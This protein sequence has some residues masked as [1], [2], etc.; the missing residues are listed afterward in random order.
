MERASSQSS[1]D[2]DAQ[3]V[4]RAPEVVVNG[5]SQDGDSC[6]TAVDDAS[7]ELLSNLANTVQSVYDTLQAGTLTEGY[8]SDTVSRLRGDLAQAKG[9]LLRCGRHLM[10]VA[11]KVNFLSDKLGVTSRLIKTKLQDEHVPFSDNDAE[12]GDIWVLE[13]AATAHSA[14]AQAAVDLSEMQKLASEIAES[15]YKATAAAE[16]CKARAEV[17]DGH[18]NTALDPEQSETKGADEQSET[19]TKR[20]ETGD[21]DTVECSDDTTDQQKGS[22]HVDDCKS[23]KDGEITSEGAAEAEGESQGA[24]GNESSS[25]SEEKQGEAAAAD[26]SE[27]KPEIDAAKNGE[28]ETKP[29]HDKEKEKDKEN[30]DTA[31]PRQTQAAEVT[32]QQHEETQS[33]KSVLYNPSD[34]PLITFPVSPEIDYADVGVACVV[35]ALEDSLD[36]MQIQ[37]DVIDSWDSTYELGHLESSVSNIVRLS[38]KGDVLNF[39]VPVFVALPY[40]PPRGGML[41]ESALVVMANCGDGKWTQVTSHETT[42]AEHKDVR[43]LEIPVHE[44]GCLT[45]LIVTKLKVDRYTVSSRGGRFASSVDA[46]VFVVAPKRAFGAGAELT[47]QVC[48]IDST[49]LGELKSRFDGCDGILS[50]S[51]V[52]TLRTTVIPDKPLSVS[53]PCQQSGGSRARPRSSVPQTDASK[54]SS[55]NKRP[56][57]AW[58]ASR[59]RDDDESAGDEQIHIVMKCD[60]NQWTLGSDLEFRVIRDSVSIDLDEFSSSIIVLRVAGSVTSS[61]LLKMVANLE[62]QLAERAVTM[63]VRQREDDMAAVHIECCRSNKVARLLDK[64]AADG[65]TY[66]PES[67]CIVYVRDGDRLEIT[68]RGNLCFDDDDTFRF[69]FSSVV[70]TSRRDTF[71]KEVDRFAQHG[72]DYYRG[73]VQLLRTT[74]M[75]PGGG[76]DGACRQMLCELPLTLPKPP[77]EPTVVVRAPVKVEETGP[78][79]LGYFHELSQYIGDEWQ[80]LAER[81][82]IK[83]PRIQSL[84]RSNPKV[85]SRHKNIEDMLMQWY[86]RCPK[87][88]DK[89]ADLYYSLCEVGREDLAVELRERNN[90]FLERADK[91]AEEERIQRA[92]RAVAGSPSVMRE[93]PSVARELSLTEQEIA[94]IERDNPGP[95]GRRECCHMTLLAWREKRGARAT[96]KHLIHTMRRLK[97]REVAGEV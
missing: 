35:R 40:S 83:R 21:E 59:S 90:E 18:L 70:K 94:D 6:D 15:A 27:T 52:V 2:D 53:V 42:F 23:K 81:L 76:Q 33:S 13:Q 37:C 11:D 96:R 7:L 19:E 3:S 10:T 24:A 41:R 36:K 65:Y 63:V 51:P 5:S 8:E 39:E 69:A 88:H 60:D 49:V 4:D 20:G 78:L 82:G 95:D 89:V 91:T 68:F 32:G 80:L 38:S 14:F 92:I 67:K 50:V 74:S 12:T 64:L 17:V 46:R 79:T 87:R 44:I 61:E 75:S 73:H 47:M 85:G 30:T 43:F 55:M 26:V 28:K 1:E 22:D 93:W 84:M 48:P 86:K 77:M 72:L 31:Q 71:V 58:P 9:T 62:R 56:S 54:G 97:F 34:W 29:K 45:L 66:G 57:T 25:Q 16:R